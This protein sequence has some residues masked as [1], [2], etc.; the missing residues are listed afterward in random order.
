VKNVTTTRINISQQYKPTSPY[1][2]R[3]HT[4]SSCGEALEWLSVCSEVQMICI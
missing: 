2:H 1:S 4:I 3:L